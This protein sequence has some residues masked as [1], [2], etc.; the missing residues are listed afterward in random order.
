MTD[1]RK[2][3]EKIYGR[4]VYKM[5]PDTSFNDFKIG[6]HA[7][8]ALKPNNATWE[9]FIDRG[10]YDQWAVRPIGDKDFN[11]QQLFH[12]PSMEEAEAL[13]DLLNGKPNNEAL[14]GEIEETP[15]VL[16]D[17]DKIPYKLLRS[18]LVN[19]ILTELKKR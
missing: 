13:R 9:C 5:W 6:W 11:S 14:I 19:Q 8:A 4:G 12:V 1:I 10:Y 16:M 18:S 2:E 7:R 17:R 3:F 15:D